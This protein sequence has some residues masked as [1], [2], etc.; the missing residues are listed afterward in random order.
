[1]YFIRLL[2]LLFCAVALAA[3][4]E[5][6][7]EKT[8]LVTQTSQKGETSSSIKD[9][10]SESTS[11]GSGGVNV[12]ILPE[13]PTSSD[14]LQAAIQG[15]P[16]SKNIVWKVNDEIVSTGTDPQLCNVSFK[17]ND[18]VSVEVGTLDKG[19]Q[20]SVSIGN[21]LP[22]VIDISS[23]PDEIFAGVDVSVSPVAEDADDDDVSFTY[24]WLVNG[25]AD[26]LLTEATLPG[27]K[28]SKGDTIQVLIV[29]NDFFEDGP[30][31]ESYAQL[32]P[33]AAPMIISEPPQS[34]SS[35]DYRY[36]VEVSDPD[37]SQF[38]YRLDEAPDGMEI[39]PASGLIRW[40]L[41]DIVPGDYTIAIIV[42]DPEGAEGA[43]E[44][45]L[46]LGAP[47]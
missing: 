24:Q 46:T 8:T 25:A 6:T 14:C 37:D 29:P 40:S 5:E 19:A 26:P 27:N 21:S 32:V 43:Q 31:Y 18:T 28:F 10:Q 12:R 36:Q 20:V 42:T 3:C 41:A 44:Y 22:R 45:S 34:I 47:E 11:S 16:G 39:D 7:P 9:N 1:M 13:S 38:T 30:T 17:R 23:T 33:N 2:L 35:L 15:G 4:S